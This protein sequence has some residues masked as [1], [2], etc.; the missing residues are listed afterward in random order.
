MVIKLLVFNINV[1]ILL[2]NINFVKCSIAGISYMDPL[3]FRHRYEI[4]KGEDPCH[5]L[6]WYPRHIP[7]Y[8]YYKIPPHSII[9]PEV[10]PCP[11]KPPPVAAVTVA[12]SDPIPIPVP[13]ALPIL[14]PSPVMQVPFPMPYPI[15]P[16]FPPIPPNMYS[17][18]LVSQDIGF[19]P[20]VPGIVSHDGGINIL[21]FSDVYADVLERKKQKLIT[22]RLREILE[23]YNDFP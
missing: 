4:P 19:V 17:P 1:M 7:D 21:P 14:P 5:P 22:K 11:V 12:S 2:S 6:Y 9:V 8:C 15:P 23:D 10:T 20:P 13:I 16:M 18:P 3:D